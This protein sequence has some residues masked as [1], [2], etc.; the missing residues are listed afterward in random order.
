M[1]LPGTGRNGFWQ[2]LLVHQGGNRWGK[3][4]TLPATGVAGRETHV[5]KFGTESGSGAS[6]LGVG[7]SSAQRNLVAVETEAADLARQALELETA[8]EVRQ[9]LND[10]L[11]RAGLGEIVHESV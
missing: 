6:R 7:Y 3:E 1:A 5:G 4:K 2:W 9:L 11:R 8:R 10:A